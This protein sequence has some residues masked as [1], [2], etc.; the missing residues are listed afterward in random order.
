MQ[1]AGD[2]F[3]LRRRS[4]LLERIHQLEEEQVGW[5]RRSRR[6]RSSRGS[7]RSRRSRRQYELEERE[8]TERC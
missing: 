8:K 2:V 1:E 5:S 7:R 6:S 4:H 3:L